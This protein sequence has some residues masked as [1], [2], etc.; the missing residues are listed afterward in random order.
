MAIIKKAFKTLFTEGPVPFLKKTANFARRLF[1]S[2][3]A[4]INPGVYNFT[5][6]YSRPALGAKKLDERF[7]KFDANR[8]VINWIVVFICF[9]FR[10]KFCFF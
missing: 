1:G 7:K 4:N 5:L 10:L 9:L 2:A 3:P 8:L 6:D